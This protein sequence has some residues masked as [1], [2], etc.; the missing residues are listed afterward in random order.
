MQ[1]RE[2]YQNAHVTVHEKKPPCTPWFYHAEPLS[3]G[4]I[5]RHNK[6]EEVIGILS[7]SVPR[8]G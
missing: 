7:G 5:L 2:F 6:P 4:V 1:D 3:Y 8:P